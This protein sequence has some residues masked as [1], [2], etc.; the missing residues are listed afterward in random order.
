MDQIDPFKG[1]TSEQIVAFGKGL[2][3]STAIS[4]G[5]KRYFDNLTSEGRDELCR[6][7]GARWTDEE[8]QKASNRSKTQWAGYSPGRRAEELG[9]VFLNEKYREKFRQFHKNMSFKDRKEWVGRSFCRKWLE[10]TEEEKE[11]IL[12]L[13]VNS[14]ASHLA[15]RKSNA[16][17]PSEPELFLGMF[18][19]EY[20]SCRWGYNGG[21]EQGVVIG[22]KIP[23][24]TNINGKKSVIEVFGRYWHSE[25]EVEPLIA[26]YKKYGYDCLVLWDYECYDWSDELRERVGRV[27]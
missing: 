9:K 18:L 2:D 20:F 25:D 11:G 4:E 15:S 7:N 17:G 27:S 6:R 24:Y 23:D 14:D 16:D 8:R 3:R 22:R 21:G 5:T 1:F 19:E 13:S 26:H 12:S 10:C